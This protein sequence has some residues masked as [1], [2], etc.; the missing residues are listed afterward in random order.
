[1][2][3]PPSGMNLPARKGRW[4]TGT[5]AATVAQLFLLVLAGWV[6]RHALNPDGVAY[7][8][9]AGYYAH[10]QTGLAVSGYWGPLLSWLMTPLLALGLS[11]LPVARMVMALTAVFFLRSCL[12]V[13]R[14][15]ELPEWCQ[16]FG[17]WLAVVVSVCWSVENITPDLVSA[18][19][20]GYAVCFMVRPRWHERWSSAA[21]AGLLWGLAFLA[22]A[23]A[24]PLALAVTA[25]LAA[26]W[27]CNG[28]RDGKRIGRSVLATL[29]GFAIIAG[30]WVAVISAKYQRLTISRSAQLNHAMVGPSD[31]ERFYPLD[32]GLQAPEAGRVTFWE[33]PD[34]PYSDWSPLASAANAQHQLQIILQNTPRVVFM[35][36]CVCGLF[37]FLLL[38]F[39]AKLFRSEPRQTLARERWW[40]AWLP[41]IALGATYLSGNLLI[42]EQ[43]Y[44]YA[45]FPFL[46]VLCAGM[47]MGWKPAGFAAGQVRCWICAV[48]L[49]FLLPTLARP[50]VWR[51]PGSTAADCAWTLSR[52]LSVLDIS[53]PVASSAQIRG[54]RAGM[55]VAFHLGVPWYGDARQPSAAEFDQS[56]AQLIIV[57]RDLPVCAELGRDTN[58]IDLDGRLFGSPDEAAR[59]PL[60]A[61]QTASP[62]AGNDGG[63]ARN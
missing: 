28:V 14:A 59:F 52:R 35:L 19:L 40:W 17:A 62:V 58:F 33:D 3:N 42:S 24:F 21:C 45:A 13:F 20:V 31:V 36:T 30:P 12:A 49:A 10:G 51:P 32:R 2:D 15:F 26:A 5:S 50:T 57:N 61:F 18:G 34:L 23:A 37:P 63:N 6:R 41:V 27:W 60:K 55:Y 53:G 22:K 47:F 44:F 25:G 39:A 11:P 38:V 54:G 56:R 4:L 7:L 48:T 16:R 1:M 9:I 29:L 43:R 8:R 46:F